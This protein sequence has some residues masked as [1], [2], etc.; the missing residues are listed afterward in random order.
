MIPLWEVEYEVRERGSIGNFTWMGIRVIAETKEEAGREALKIIHREYPNLEPRA[1]REII[2]EED[3]KR[4]GIKQQ[5]RRKYD[6][7]SKK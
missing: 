1:P 6:R 2:H 4:N 7:T 3:F 5:T